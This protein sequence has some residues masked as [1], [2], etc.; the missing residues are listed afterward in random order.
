MTYYHKQLVI[1]N[2]YKQHTYFLL[3][4]HCHGFGGTFLYFPITFCPE[5][6]STSPNPRHKSLSQ[7]SHS[8]AAVLMSFLEGFLQKLGQ[9]GLL[10]APPR[11]PRQAF[12]GFLSKT[13]GYGVSMGRCK[14]STPGWLEWSHAEK[15]LPMRNSIARESSIPRIKS[16]VFVSFVCFQGAFLIWI[17]HI[18]L[19]RHPKLAKGKTEPNLW[20]G[21]VP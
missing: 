5:V 10:A 4:L 16:H 3:L 6:G 19:V 2:K 8:L 20:S 7:C 17:K 14:R 21:V 15:Y 9:V 12:A 13:T 18:L 11:N 1:L